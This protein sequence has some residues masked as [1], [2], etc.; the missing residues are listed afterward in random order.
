MKK[1]I[2]SLFIA[3]LMLLVNVIPFTVVF[4]VE[5]SDIDFDIKFTNTS[6]LVWINDKVVLDDQDY[7]A[8]EFEGTINNAGTTSSSGTNTLKFSASFGD[9]DI[10]EYVINGVTYTEESPEVTKTEDEPIPGI[11]AV[12]YSIVVPG[13]SKYTIRGTAVQTGN[14]PRTI[15]WGN[16]GATDN[17]AK[18]AQIYNGTAKIIAVYDKDNHLV[19]ESVY[20]QPNTV[21]GVDSNNNGW[22]TIAP[23]S[24]VVFEFVPNY[25]YQLTKVEANEM[26][27]EAQDKTNQYTFIMPDTNVHFSATFTKTSDIV[28][29]K[30][31]AIS[32]GSIKLGK[33]LDAGTGQLT[34]EDSDLSSS[35]KTDFEEAA[36]EYKI[37]NFVNIDFYNVFYKGKSDSDD[38]WKDKKEDLEEYATVTI[39]LE[40]GIKAKDVVIIHNVH[41]GTKYEV[42]EIESYDEVNNTVTFK[43]KSFSNFA[44]ATKTSNPKTGDNMI[45]YSIVLGLSVIG[46]SVIGLYIKKR[47]LVK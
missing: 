43:V 20:T 9:H 42:I 23:G 29:S 37:E 31:N 17:D 44:I 38:V 19:D 24:K 13:A 28:K 41:D 11:V 35:K 30:T 40:D 5:E 12:T 4:A 1:K 22:A 33:E 15:I 46:L 16:P 27:L 18:D 34:I 7:P 21:G 6:V 10:T 36:G 8:D 14:V 3:V 25:G 39:K 2:L 32:S 45:F 47:L 26:A